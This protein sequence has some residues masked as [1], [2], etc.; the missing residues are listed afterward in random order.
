MKKLFGHISLYL[1]GLIIVLHAIFPHVHHHD[2][3]DANH[4]KIHQESEIS[5]GVNLNF[6]FHELTHEGQMEQVE[7]VAASELSVVFFNCI[8]GADFY[9][10]MNTSQEVS[11]QI[12]EL[13]IIPFLTFIS[14][15]T[16][17]GYVSSW[18]FRAPPIA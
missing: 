8:Y 12:S 11:K 2:V 14:T 13:P 5:V 4:L 18:G 17:K 15:Q 10:F 3:S 9:S 7:L 6:L 1:A 16:A